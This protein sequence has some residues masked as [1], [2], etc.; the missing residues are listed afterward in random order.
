MRNKCEDGSK[1]V[2]V[3]SVEVTTISQK[4]RK[5]IWFDEVL[6]INYMLIEFW[7][8]VLLEKKIWR[9]RDDCLFKNK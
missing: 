8:F 2:I 6:S 4:Q 9:N 3:L 1:I 7:I 5:I